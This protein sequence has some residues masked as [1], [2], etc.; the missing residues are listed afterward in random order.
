MLDI[1]RSDAF[2]VT[3]LTDS[4]NTMPYKPGRLGALG[5]F[6]SKGIRTTTVTIEEKNGTLRLI[7]TSPRG[8]VPSNEGKVKR[9]ARSF[10]VP[11]LE[12]ESNITADECQNVRQ[13]GSEDQTL[14]VQTLVDEQQATLRQA[15]E[16][17]LERHRM[18][19][20]QGI[21]L[22]AD[23]DQL[24]NL[25]TAFGVSQHTG[26]IAVDD[27]S[28]DGDNLRRQIRGL[29]REI[30][31]ELKAERALVTGYRAFCGPDFI[32]N[33]RSDVGVVNTLRYADPN[34]LRENQAEGA[35]FN[36]GGVAWE[37]YRGSVEDEDG[38]S[39][40]FVADDEAYLVPVGPDVFRTYFAP[41]DFIEAVNTLGLP[42]YTKILP[43][44]SG[45]NRFV[46]VHT[47]SNPLC[48]NVR[49][50]AVIKLTITT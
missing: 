50:R 14:A 36:F 33:L 22:D 30:E 25:F 32:D 21:I 29:Q 23:G 49:P 8:G 6:R 5:L 24:I 2:G 28:D 10:P 27:A 45:A 1:F 43:D 44:P 35:A 7:Q 16:V 9:T 38:D 3:T 17:T 20:L 13:F 47:Q 11:H 46:K 18:G 19:A 4:I 12:R 39:Q 31:D 41:A 26:V 40:D 42:I 34:A 15:H 48:L 37:E